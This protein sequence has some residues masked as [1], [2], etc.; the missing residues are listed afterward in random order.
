[1]KKEVYCYVIEGRKI[2]QILDLLNSE[3]SIIKLGLFCYR[4]VRFVGRHFGL[5]IHNSL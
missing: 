5:I 4:L 1:M 3:A 2:I